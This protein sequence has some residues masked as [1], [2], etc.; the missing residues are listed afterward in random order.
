MLKSIKLML[1]IFQCMPKLD[2]DLFINFSQLCLE[3]RKTE[4]SFN[5]SN[6]SSCR[7]S[8]GRF[9]ARKIEG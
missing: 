4:F 8:L 5:C 6:F 9:G 7:T 1:M 2:F 3:M